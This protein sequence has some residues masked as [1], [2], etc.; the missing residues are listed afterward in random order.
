MQAF[1]WLNEAIHIRNNDLIYTQSN[2]VNVKPIQKKKKKLSQ[3]HPELCLTKYL[4]TLW[5]SQI[6]T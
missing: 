2:S 5:S 1:N 6:D 4:S 3:K